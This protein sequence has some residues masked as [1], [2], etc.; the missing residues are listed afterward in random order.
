MVFFFRFALIVA[1]QNVSGGSN[2]SSYSKIVEGSS[3]SKQPS[4]FGSI[5]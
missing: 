4:T 3:S 1:F 5:P 2:T